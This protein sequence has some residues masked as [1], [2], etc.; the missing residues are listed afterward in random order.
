MNITKLATGD[1]M[2]YSGSQDLSEMRIRDVIEK[3]VQFIIAIEGQKI[4][5]VF[6]ILN[7]LKY[8]FQPLDNGCCLKNID[9]GENFCVIEENGSIS[10]LKTTTADI[11]VITNKR[12][13]PRGVVSHLQH[14][15]HLLE[16]TEQANSRVLSDFLEYKR[17]V[18]FLE[19]EI[20]VTDA[21]GNILF[22]NPHGEKVC[23][24]RAEEVVGKHVSELEKE[25]VFSSSTTLEVL[26]TK[27]K[28]NMMQR[29]KSGKTVLA[30]GIPIYENGE[31]VRILS[32]TKDVREI[33]HLMRELEHK[34]IEL[35]RKSEELN[36]LREE[37]FMQ[38][39]FIS[40]SKEMNLIKETM[41]KIA[42]TDL[43][44]MIQGESGVGKEVVTK[45]IHRLSARNKHP[46]IKINCGLIPEN[47]MESEL[48]GYE[49]GAFTG[50]SKGGKMGKIE[51]AHHGTLFLD[52]IGEMPLNLQ[53]KLLEFLQDREIT[54]VGGTQKIKIDTR[55][56]VATNRN[57]HQMVNEKR[58][59]QDLFYRLNIIPIDI[60][61][62]RERIE[63]IPVL[64]KY[65]LNK[66]NS[67]YNLNKH[68]ADDVMVSLYCYNWPG[69]VRELE[70][71]VE[72]L[73]VTSDSDVITANDLSE[74]ISAQEPNQGKVICTDLI[75]LRK[76]KKEVE[77]QLV[78]R[79]YK[80]YQSTYKAGEVLEIDQSTVVKILKKYK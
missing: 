51:L 2:V 54:R 28:V 55:V 25:K 4:I 45:V 42:P 31:M 77:E 57:L 24:V 66:F 64:A 69:N 22:L 65:F 1:F 17:I 68:F 14:F 19:E 72:R 46:L 9:G 78:K 58:F 32:T 71:V 56:I 20:F 18:E 10:E 12:G 59:R 43:T 52:E 38:E 8:L 3:K 13:L 73:T 74:I 63:D 50:A 49:S 47:L 79:A 37:V 67:K 76:A 44:V 27:K 48:F 34:D 53:V 29:L 15:L 40:G 35:E 61:P 26:R 6:K 39:K 75:P 7:F 60:P 62:L 23:G 41:L 70:H 21:K 5:K 30:I 80:I 36:T 33:N 11:A 16:Y